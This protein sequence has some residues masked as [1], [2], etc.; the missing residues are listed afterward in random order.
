MCISHMKDVDGCVSASIIKCAIQ[1][2][3]LI[4]NY[5]NIN[6]CLS[7]VK[8][9]DK[10]YICDLGLNKTNLNELLRIRRFA[11]ITYIDHHYPDDAL[12]NN[13]KERKF[14]RRKLI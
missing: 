10:V 14:I 11:E 6:K 1:A 7:Y 8:D 9:Y 5:G 13:L 3:F 2:N 12:L 4:S